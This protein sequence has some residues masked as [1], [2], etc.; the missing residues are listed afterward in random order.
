MK[1]NYYES[2][3]LSS[4]WERKLL[5]R[6]QFH[7]IPTNERCANN[8]FFFLRKTRKNYINRLCFRNFY[9][10]KTDKETKKLVY[11]TFYSI[12]KIKKRNLSLCTSISSS[13]WPGSHGQPRYDT[14][15]PLLSPEVRATCQLYIVSRIIQGL[16]QLRLGVKRRC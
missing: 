3:L 5:A 10:S 1:K 8:Y 7:Y 16:D 6:N 15:S 9:S 4:R 14:L 13:S 11:I 12:R 2:Q